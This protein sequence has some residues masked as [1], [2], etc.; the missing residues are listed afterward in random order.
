MLTPSQERPLLEVENLSVVFPTPRGPVIAVDR[1]S[2]RLAKGE[3]LGLVGESGSG[4]SSAALA[5][6]RLVPSPGSVAQG[7][8]RFQ[9]DELMDLPEPRLREIR[10]RG[11]GFVF[12]EPGVALNPLMRIGSQM[13]EGPIVHLGL[14]RHQGWERGR[15]LLGE[16][17]IADPEACMWAYPFQLSG[18]MRQRALIA[19]ALACEPRLLI[20]DEPTSALDVSVQAQIIELLK[21]IQRKR[22]LSM[23]IISHDWGVIA[24]LADRV[25]VMYAGRI[26]EEGAAADVFQSPSHPY[27]QLLLQTVPRL[28]GRD[29]GAS[30]GFLPGSAPDLAN[31]PSGCA[32]H[33]RCP[34]SDPFCTE[35]APPAT[36]IGSGRFVRCL[37]RGPAA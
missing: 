13:A 11:I 6:L 15:R 31:L 35:T 19:M 3:T 1:V 7:S 20:G 2:L 17:G 27:T 30:P 26:I 9:G 22:G 32:F 8:I 23:L 12:Q 21:R 36:R 28:S 37:K 25:A 34:E 33:P 10:G 16:V 14:S 5:L 24:Q 18:G 4:K 29:R